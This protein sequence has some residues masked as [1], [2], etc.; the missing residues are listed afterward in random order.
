ML[1][2][3]RVPALRRPTRAALRAPRA[4]ALHASGARSFSFIKNVMDQVKKDMEKSKQ[5][6]QYQ[7][8]FK[9]LENQRQKLRLDEA[10]AK[11]RERA[12]QQEEKL[13]GAQE[14][15]ANMFDTVKDAMS[16]AS[17]KV[18]E[19]MQDERMKPV[20][21]ASE[22]VTEGLGRVSNSV[23]HGIGKFASFFDDKEKA[24]KFWAEQDNGTAEKNGTADP[25]TATKENGKARDFSGPDF[26]G[27]D[28]AA[29]PPPQETGL[30]LHHETVW[31]RFGARVRDMP[32]LND[33]YDNPLFER[34]FGETEIA[35]S[36]REMKKFDPHFRLGEF[37]EEVEDIVAPHL[38]KCYLEGKSDVL[39]MQLGDAAYA[40]VNNSIDARKK[41]RMS[42]DPTLLDGPRE[43]ELAGA[44]LQDNGAPLF[45][46]TFFTQQINCMRNHEGMVVEGDIDDIR[47]VRWLVAVTKH[48]EPETPGLLHPWQVSEFAMIQNHESW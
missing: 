48:P 42:M 17:S 25:S 20:A 16:K 10:A 9:E 12:R 22:K 27:P 43:V 40:A 24:K 7:E 6:P 45:I 26:S 47:T 34:M 38:I 14:Q 33:V 37:T 19:T 31:D 41:M 32:F 35:S 5:D 36:I 15:S 3:L 39:K 30:V 2:T 23:T 21:E 4:T 46:F 11:L 28:F 8:A 29:Q 1:S 18:S 44:A 13:K